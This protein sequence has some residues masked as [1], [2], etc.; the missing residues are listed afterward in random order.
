M[1]HDNKRVY[2][3]DVSVKKKF[4]LHDIQ[5]QFQHI[6]T[7]FQVEVEDIYHTNTLQII[8]EPL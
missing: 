6:T 5:L 7:I 3:I 2:L 4:S 8:I 1:Q